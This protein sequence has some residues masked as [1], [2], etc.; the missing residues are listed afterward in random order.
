MIPAVEGRRARFGALRERLFEEGFTRPRLTSLLASEGPLVEP[1][2]KSIAAARAREGGTLGLLA[3]LFL[4]GETIATNELTGVTSLMAELVARGLLR[5]QDGLTANLILVPHDG[6]LI[7]SDPVGVP[8]AADFVPAVQGPSRQLELFALRRP[9]GRALDLG[10]GNGYQA[11]LLSTSA[12]EV[13]ATDVNPR[14]LRY[15]DLNLALNGVTNVEL[16]EGSFFDPVESERFDTA[17]SNPPF[18]ISPETGYVFRDSSIGGEE[19][20]RLVVRGISELLGPAGAATVLV[21]WDAT[22]R[23]PSAVPTSWL[24]DLPVDA[25]VLPYQVV[26]ARVNA[27]RWTSMDDDPATAA[28]TWIAYYRAR[29]IEKIGYGAVVMRATTRPARRGVLQVPSMPKS[30]ATAHLTRLLEVL[31]RSPSPPDRVQLTAATELTSV[32]APTPNG[33]RERSGTLAMLDG[34]GVTVSL[35]VDALEVVRSLYRA[36]AVEALVERYGSRAQATVARL[37][38]FGF[39]EFVDEAAGADRPGSLIVTESTSS[40]PST[41]GSRRSPRQA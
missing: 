9:G 38:E 37:V 17:V 32:S 26:D 20:S 34:L 14:A 35:D 31:D 5:D 22:G 4:L 25:L 16:R 3:R 27:E 13:V 30:Q 40:G 29:G 6:I 11:I 12:E 10:T 28:A 24:G 15:A 21:S 2:R 39:L 23:D 1:G 7:A 36:T 19:V 41:S 18:V 8:S 33:W